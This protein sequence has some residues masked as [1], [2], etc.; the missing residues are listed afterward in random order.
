MGI[1]CS[2]GWVSSM[3]RLG[4]GAKLSLPGQVLM[5]HTTLLAPSYT[6]RASTAPPAADQDCNYNRD[7]KNI[8]ANL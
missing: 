4:R 5:L 7:E 2:M 8:L 1:I 6:G 3:H